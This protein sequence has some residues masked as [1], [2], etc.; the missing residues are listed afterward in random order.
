ML[1]III[2]NTIC[3]SDLYIR[4][5]SKNKLEIIKTLEIFPKALVVEMR[6]QI[7]GERR[8]SP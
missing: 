2:V 6:K 3:G 4:N 1:A 8:D 7:C 5:T